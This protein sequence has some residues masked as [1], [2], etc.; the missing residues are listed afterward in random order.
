MTLDCIKQLLCKFKGIKLRQRNGYFE[1]IIIL[2]MRYYTT[3]NLVG[4]KIGYFMPII[5]FPIGLLTI[6]IDKLL[7][8]E[9]LTTGY[10]ISAL[11]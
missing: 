1:S 4:R 7:P 5:F 6:L 9:E 3:K 11:K 10:Y 8:S 2:L